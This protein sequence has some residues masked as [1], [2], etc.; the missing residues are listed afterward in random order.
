MTNN[1][2][3]IF[4][5]Q[6]ID[7]R[8]KTKYVKQNANFIVQ[9]FGKVND[10]EYNNIYVEVYGFEPCFYIQYR[11]DIKKLLKKF[12]DNFKKEQAKKTNKFF[13]SNN[14]YKIDITQIKLQNFYGFRG[15]EKEKFIKLSS[16]N[17]F[18]LRSFAKYCQKINILTFESNKDPLIQFIHE[19][20]LKTCGWICINKYETLGYVPNEDDDFDE[21]DL[22][23]P[24]PTNAKYNI[25]TYYKNVL[26]INDKEDILKFVLCAYDIECISSD[27]NFPQANRIDDRIVSI[28]LTFSYLGEN[29]CFRK[30]ICIVKVN[31][32][33]CPPIKGVNVHNYNTEANMLI[34]FCKIIQA[35][36]PDVLTSW[37]GFGFD[38]NYIHER[39][40]LLGIKDNMCMSRIITEKTKFV[41][42]KLSSA[43]LG[44]NIMKYYDMSGRVNFDLMKLVQRDYKLTTYKLDYVASYFFRS[45]ITNIE[46]IEQN[47]EY[48]SKLTLKFDK[49]TNPTPTKEYS[50]DQYI[51][52]INNDDVTD[53]DYEDII[54]DT[55][56][57]RTQ[58]KSFNKF[59][60]IDILGPTQILINSFVDTSIM[61]R[62]GRILCCNV[63]DDVPPKEIFEKYRTGKP[64]ELKELC[65][66]N[67]Q[68]SNLCNKIANKNCVL[69]NNIGMA[70]VCY[71]PL[72]WI[73]NRGQSPKVYSLVSKKCRQEGFVIPTYA[74]IADTK[75]DDIYYI[76]SEDDDGKITYKKL[77][78]TI[79]SKREEDE[80]KV[81]YEG[82]Y[83]M[84]PR[85][86]LYDCIFTLDYNSLYPISMICR[87]I[88]HEMY[89][90]K[91]TEEEVQEIIKKYE[92]EYYFYPVSYTQLVS[93]DVCTRKNKAATD[94]ALNLTMYYA[95]NIEEKNNL[96]TCWFARRKQGKIGLIPEILEGLINN[97]RYVR[98][99]LQS[100]YPEGS[101]M[102]NVYEG[103]QLAYK[104]TCNSVYGQL[105]CS[106][107]IGPV[108]LQELAACTTATGREM[109]IRAKEFASET[110]PI[111]IKKALKSRNALVKYIKPMILSY[112]NE[113]RVPEM[114]KEQ[115]TKFYNRIYDDINNNLSGYKY[116][117]EVIYGDTDSIMVSMNLRKKDTN[118]I[119]R[120]VEMRDKH[121]KI[122][123]LVSYIIH[124][125]LPP[126]ENLDYEKIMTPFLILS[127][128]R[129][130]GN[131]YT[132][133]PN[134]KEYQKNM[135]IVLKRRDNAHIVKYVVGGVVDRLINTIDENGMENTEKGIEDA[136]K[137]TEQALR[138]IVDGKFNKSMYVLSKT[139]KS[140]YKNRSSIAHAVLADRIAERDPG[141]APESNDRIQYIYFV[142]PHAILQGDE[143]ETPEYINEM[144]LQ[145]NY[146]KYI[147]NQ[148][149]IPC[150]QFLDLFDKERTAK[151][152]NN[153][154]IYF[155]Q[156]TKGIN[157]INVNILDYTNNRKDNENDNEFN[158]SI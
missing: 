94:S 140:N 87:N 27:N 8:T 113:N 130:V 39:A 43:A 34:G 92:N 78:Y 40:K 81:T 54:N 58:Y 152:F 111:I 14:N 76:D 37:N 100:K 155:D 45:T 16:S 28:S 56:L 46:N 47:G 101:Y 142:N 21:D 103:L 49:K 25:K 122:G 98:K 73:F 116:K 75:K 30:D 17:Y 72:N 112:N 110:F 93:E 156:K 121:I 64:Q 23:E 29:E 35:V 136:F 51:I 137:F 66:Y 60:I 61:K 104:V 126:P 131:L 55:E 132:E 48:C 83:V 143:I 158:V 6:V 18:Y 91:D 107:E 53:Y 20:D 38:D 69:I 57:N 144:K 141:N 52:L 145:I 86:G 63:K 148:I 134:R 15:D 129:Y 12:Y 151:I 149:Q 42:K 10:E 24:P 88:S 146:K 153:I 147:S 96:K 95:E 3:D 41:E 11:P 120:G 125:F 109:L 119:L 150:S 135:G 154:Y 102:Y 50:I 124:E 99:S 85:P 115:R 90:M 19:Q 108:A 128:K 70:N 65:Q 26:P 5:F 31:D 127:K 13:I 36:D 89:I 123:K 4:N 62:K 33:G 7:W 139:L 80:S 106:Q 59:K 71:V 84:T 68:D 157:N 67:V 22:P 133:N 1:D 138:D 117:F 97:R 79:K 114:P 82:A 2:S 44:D 9:I 32:Q 77:D 74:K 105:G 118:E